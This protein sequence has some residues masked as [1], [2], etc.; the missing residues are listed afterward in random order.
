MTF[1]R[2][3]FTVAGIY[4][5]IVLL[6]LYGLEE[7]IGRDAPPPITH[8]EY[9]YGFIGV[10]VAW[11]VAFLIIG[12]DPAGYRPLMIPAM[13]E[14]A[15][16]VAA[17]AVLYALGRVEATSLVAGGADLLLGILFAVAFIKT[18]PKPAA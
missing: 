18:R 10:A 8:P 6:P 12:R 16:F 14:K 11:Q 4:G 5:L 9:F 17:V 15:S 1:A 13:I 2:R 7:Q 3:V